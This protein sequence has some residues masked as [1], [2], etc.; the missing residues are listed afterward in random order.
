MTT[1]ALRAV[2]ELKTFELSIYAT[3]DNRLLLRQDDIGALV[4]RNLSVD[5]TKDAPLYGIHGTSAKGPHH[6]YGLSGCTMTDYS[7]I[8]LLRREHQVARACPQGNAGAPLVWSTFG[9]GV[10]VDTKSAT[11][12][13]ESSSISVT[14]TSRPDL[15][16]YILVGN[17]PA[18]FSALADIS[19]HAPLFPK[20]ATGFTNSQW[21]IDQRE[22]LDIV[23][24]YRSKHIPIDNFTLDYDW[25]AWGQG[26]YGEFRWNAEKFPDGPSGKLAEELDAEGVHLTGIMKPR[27]HMHTAEGRFVSLNNFWMPSTKIHFK[28]GTTDSEIDF[29]KPAVRDWFG[30]LAMKYGLKEG[31]AGWWNDEEDNTEDDT[32]SLNMERSLYEAQRAHSTKRVW[33]INRNFWLGAQRYAY[34]LWSGDINTGFRSMAAQR[35]RMLSAIDVG[36]MEWGMDAGGFFGRPSDQ[37]YARWIEFGA[38][39]PIFRVHG[40]HNQKR[41]PWRYGPVAEAA[42]KQAIRLHYALI[43][44]IYSYAWRDHAKGVGLVTPLFFEWPHDMNVRSDVSAWMFGDWLLVSPIVKKDQTEK[45]IYLPAGSWID[46]FTGQVYEGG[47]TITVSVHSKTWDDIPLFI[48]QGAIIP[49]QEVL[50]YVEQKPIRT[51]TLDVFPT[52]QRTV[53]DYYDDDGETYGYMRG[54]YF[55]Q[56]LSVEASDRLVT[57][58]TGSVSGSFTPALKYYLVKV[59]DAQAGSVSLND[60]R[61]HM[62]ASLESLQGQDEPG[63]WTGR[64]LYG[65]VTYIKLRAGK[66]QELRIQVLGK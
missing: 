1:G 4:D 52:T 9:F 18:I 64:D 51:L 6:L 60:R 7:H 43:P 50:D 26:D 30:A 47:R 19:G 20:W 5:Y 21:G 24:T 32:Q 29:G 41:Q 59:H 15:E 55:L 13:L 28:V 49:T 14:D 40:E 48:R 42:A 27:I 45:H 57:F 34:G 8:T 16:Y 3:K 39:T 66:E 11:F 63:W 54:D 58:R 36:E 37:N 44:Y 17:P 53:F 31:M 33:S 12:N 23:K 46:Y 35:E 10:L 38:F 22:L 62:A 65:R 56:P 2:L 25:K 61:L